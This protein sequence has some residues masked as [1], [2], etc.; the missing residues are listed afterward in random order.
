MNKK[1]CQGES[2]IVGKTIALDRNVT[3]VKGHCLSRRDNSMTGG[4]RI[5]LLQRK[6]AGYVKGIMF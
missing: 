4:K 5:G 1:C 2:G 3:D 6:E